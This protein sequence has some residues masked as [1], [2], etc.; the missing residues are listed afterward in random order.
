MRPATTADLRGLAGVLARAFYDDPVMEWIWP[1]PAA[2]RRAL[3][4]FFSIS[5]RHEFLPSGGTDVAAVETGSGKHHVVGTAVWEPPARPNLP[6]WRGLLTVPGIVH[7]L[8]GRLRTGSRVA[9]AFEKARPSEPHW[10]L[11]YIGTDPTVRGT[12]LGSQ[13]IRST[14]AGCDVTGMPAYLES[15]NPANTTYYEG[16]GFEVLTEIRIPGGGPTALG[17]WRPPSA[18]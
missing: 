11:S 15:S 10:Y 12:G 18:T 4:I 8:R 6:L 3:P 7:A 16:F 17:M 13:L 2:R 14:L 1:S 9:S 5:A